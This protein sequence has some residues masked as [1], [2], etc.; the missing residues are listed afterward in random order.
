MANTKSAQKANRSS[1]RKRQ[2]NLTTKIKVK[3]ALKTFRKTVITDAS[4][5]IASLSEVFSA[6]DKAAKTNYIPKQRV[7]RKKK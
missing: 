5:S 7:N 1:L 3:N 2:F 6:L 4:S